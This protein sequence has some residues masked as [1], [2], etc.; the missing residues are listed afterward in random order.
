MT[1]MV[2]QLRKQEARPATWIRDLL[3]N[4]EARGEM[5]RAWA[6]GYAQSPRLDQERNQNV[7]M[8]RSIR[9]ARGEEGELRQLIQEAGVT[10]EKAAR[11][12]AALIVHSSLDLNQVLQSDAATLIGPR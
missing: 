10:N 7:E 4:P 5:I 1:K 8:V 6:D 2:E 3:P 9:V 12:V 11:S